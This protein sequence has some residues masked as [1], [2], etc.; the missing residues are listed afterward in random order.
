MDTE[1]RARRSHLRVVVAIGACLLVAVGLVSLRLDHNPQLSPNDVL[2]LAIAY[3]AGSEVCSG[4]MTPAC[5]H[6]AAVR[7]GH[8]IAWLASP[9]GFTTDGVHLIAIKDAP[10]NSVFIEELHSKS[11]LA[12]LQV[13]QTSNNAG[14]R[15]ETAEVG[16]ATATISHHFDFGAAGGGSFDYYA[17]WIFEGR[18]ARLEVSCDK[19]WGG[20]P[21]STKRILTDLLTG[22][23][24]AS[25]TA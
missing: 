4:P 2:H 10:G 6:Q 25:P 16:G 18:T 1:P 7:A 13:G 20:S 9:T 3:P 5:A 22:M 12:D 21:Q 8:P 14:P 23:Q 17:T 15:D 24:F 11:A 19:M